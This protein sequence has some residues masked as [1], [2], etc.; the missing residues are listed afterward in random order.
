MTK[1]Q[2]PSDR[3]FGDWM[4]HYNYIQER[5]EE[6]I[7]T[8]NRISVKLS[9]SKPHLLVIIGDSHIGG[10][11]DYKRLQAD[12]DAVANVKDAHVLLLGDLVDGYGWGEGSSQ[13]SLGSLN[14]EVHAAHAL[15]KK[16]KGK[17]IAG[18]AGDHDYSW[19]HRGGPSM[20]HDF[21][22]RTG[23]HFFHGPAYVDFEMG[24]YTLKFAGQH[25]HMGSSIRSNT[26]AA[27][28]MWQEKASDCDLVV[29]GHNHTKGIQE[30]AVQDSRGPRKITLGVIGSYKK[31][32]SWLNKQGYGR[33]DGD[34]LGGLAFILHKDGRL[35]H[36]YEVQEA[37]ERYSGL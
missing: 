10:D 34:Q 25:R 26:A 28:R 4:D 9:P 21:I 36:F 23:A 13:D 20:Y 12:V 33:Q 17:I 3:D 7:P 32:D 8:L 15:L 5:R 30:F 1:P 27:H 31:G 37:V 24:K 29:V 16:L 2:K 35:E 6:I 18:W 14:E 19:A 11:C 22:D